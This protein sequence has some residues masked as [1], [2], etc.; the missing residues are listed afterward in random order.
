MMPSKNSELD[1]VRVIVELIL[2]TPLRFE[3]LF[4]S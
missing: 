2:C 3:D 1:F 4:A